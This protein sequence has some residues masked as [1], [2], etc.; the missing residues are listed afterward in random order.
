M[1]AILALEDGQIYR[2]RGFGTSGERA[3]EVVFNTSLFGYQE[4]LTD[5]SYA[6]Q[7]II[8]T[9][10]HIGNYGTNPNDVESAQAFAEGLV[11]RE[12]SQMSSNWRASEEVSDYLVRINVP[13]ISHIDTRAL[14]RRLREFGSMR[15]VL[16]TADQNAERL[17]AKAKASPPMVGRDLASG[18]TTRA[19]YDWREPCVRIFDKGSVPSPT[20]R[21][22][23]TRFR[24][25]A[26]DFGIK[27]N[28]LRQLVEKGCLVTVVPASTP[29]EEVLA[30]KPDGVFLS[31]GPGDPE[32]LEYATQNIRKLI[33]RVPIFG[34]CLGHQVLGLA[35][36]GKTFKLKFG[37]HGANHPVMNLATRKIEITAQNHGFV[38]DPDS[39]KVSEI[40][41]THMNL[42]D[43]TLEG[44]KHKSLP[45]FGVQYHPEASP[46]PHDSQYLFDD[47]LALMRQF[48]KRN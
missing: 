24:V 3:G 11:V 1:E 20:G 33:G 16:S 47:F 35:L 19:P 31:N 9:Y 18:V 36:G 30:R 43:Y 45:L 6:G 28:I 7:I 25:V 14:V 23:A 40:E 29:A 39:L 32:P 13:A 10:P 27:Q 48:S 12:L 44:L 26:Y 4:I 15:G 22:S 17:V 46:G 41:L 2:G 8:L 5:P 34:I 42:N 21:G 38:V 37:H